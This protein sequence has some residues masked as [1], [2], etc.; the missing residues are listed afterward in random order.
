MR[1]D[2]AAAVLVSLSLLSGCGGQGGGTE[3]GGG[4]AGGG[5]KKIR[6]GFSMDTL[7]EERWQ[8]D[9]DLVVAKGKEL[10][11]EVLVQA[12]RRIGIRAIIQI[13]HDMDIVFGYSDRIVAL[14]Q[15]R[16]LADA[17]PDVIRAN[18]DVIAVVV[19]QPR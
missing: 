2:P 5:G 14:H 11:A 1:F 17:T 19:G 18:A 16:V 7:K 13:E 3:G 8:R 15:G 6:I 12:A 10:G 4:Q 9:R